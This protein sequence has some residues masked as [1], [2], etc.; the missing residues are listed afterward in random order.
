MDREQQWQAIA[1]ERTS[2][3]D[4]LEDRPPADWDRPSLCADWRVRDVVAHLIVAADLR[5][6]P[7]TIELIRAGGSFNRMV[8][9]SARRRADRQPGTLLAELRAVSD[10]RR[11]P[12][13]T[14]P[15]NLLMDVLVH[16]QDIAI[17]LGLDR[18]MPVAAARAAADR[19]WAIGFP[20]HARRRF[21][22]YRLAAT[23]TDW[24]R[25]DGPAVEGPIDAL[26]LLL[27][28]RT[29]SLP[30]L[31]GDGATELSTR[32]SARGPTT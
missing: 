13:G 28:G 25:G 19:L 18:P 21:G 12:P 7:A 31:A 15:E 22:G 5:P 10:A 26:L 20:F 4:L 27:A 14:G 6:L 24:T 29:A 3:A 16:G 11:V 30:R 2:L 8:R 9:D 1:A 17:P 23:D 32:L